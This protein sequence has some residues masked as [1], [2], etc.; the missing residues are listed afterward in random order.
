MRPQF[1]DFDAD[2]H[3]DV[4]AATYDGSPHVA[5]GSAE[6]FL[7]PEHVLDPAGDRVML[8]QFWNYDEEKWD[9][10]S[11]RPKGHCTSAFA[12]DWDDDGDLDILMGDYSSGRLFRRM[13]EG[14][15]AEPDFGGPNVPVEAGGRPFEHRGGL[16]TPVMF[17]WDEDG[18]VDLVCGGYGATYG[19]GDG[20][21]VWW[22]RNAGERG[23]PRFEPGRPLIPDSEKGWEA[24]RR[25][26]SG[27]YVDP[28]DVDGDGL[29]DLLVGG[30]SH[31][32]PPGRE[33]TAEEEARADALQEE[34][35]EA[36]EAIDS[37][38]QKLDYSDL[39]EEERR[40]AVQQLLS[41]EE[42]TT[43]RETLE[44][45]REALQEL[46]PGPMREAF[47]WLYRRV[48]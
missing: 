44:A 27:L 18:L 31:W 12:F 22:Y 16:S 25:P 24:P 19:D 30:Y 42:Y 23:A 13:N 10:S 1:V 45:K 17:D 34:I 41:S 26:D 15:A 33:L 7:E 47:V 48:E 20:A 14:T 38:H 29:V 32:T 5:R 46:R 6:G 37:F 21:G 11:A 3:V 8:S 43:L 28:T 9:E 2:G 36:Q 35:A 39:D 40:K 4:F